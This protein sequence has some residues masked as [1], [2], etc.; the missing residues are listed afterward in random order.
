LNK[1]QRKK[2]AL[3]YIPKEYRKH[4]VDDK[5]LYFRV[6]DFDDYGPL[7]SMMVVDGRRVIH[8]VGLP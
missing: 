8:R 4:W 5:N 7:M 2:R 6:G 1:R 3:R